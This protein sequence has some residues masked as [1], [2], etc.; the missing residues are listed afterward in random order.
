[1]S[2]Q[3]LQGT[4]LL[5]QKSEYRPKMKV[6]ASEK[7]GNQKAIRRVALGDMRN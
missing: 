7:F 5:S 3:N 4:E 1:M 2:N 6:I